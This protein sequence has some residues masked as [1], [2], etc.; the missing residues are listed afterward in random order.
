MA[1]IHGDGDPTDEQLKAAAREATEDFARRW[2]SQAD[3]LLVRRGDE[4]EYEVQKIM[5]GSIWGGWNEAEEAWTFHYTHLA[6]PFF[7]F[8]TDPHPIRAKNAE[9]LAFPWPEMEGEEFGNTGM[10]FE[11]V[12]SDSWPTVFFKEVM[13]PGTEPLRFVTD[14]HRRVDME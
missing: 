11:E 9:F 12:F 14:S 13:H 1:D 4:H 8:G 3:Q 10:T 7:E 6:A 5:Q 2:H